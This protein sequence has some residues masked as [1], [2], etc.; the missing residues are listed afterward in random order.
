MVFKDTSSRSP[1]LHKDRFGQNWA[2]GLP[3]APRPDTRRRWPF[4]TL[5]AGTGCGAHG[6]LG[7]DP[8]PSQVTAGS[9]HIFISPGQHG[10]CRCVPAAGR[11]QGCGVRRRGTRPLR[12]LR[13]GGP[14]SPRPA[15]RT[16]SQSWVQTAQ[17][18]AAGHHRAVRCSE[19]CSVRRG[20]LVTALWPVLSCRCPTAPE[21][22]VLAVRTDRQSVWEVGPSTPEVLGD[23]R[24]ATWGGIRAEGPWSCPQRRP[25]AAGDTGAA[26]S[27]SPQGQR[28]L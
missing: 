25:G 15:G 4:P 18:E 21:Q 3:A 5:C 26:A 12:P 17:P 9:C 16:A 19:G 10:F 1:V 23:F 13:G 22:A 11:T 20:A 24:A 27:V 6:W 8:L 14:G 7:K 2:R 28:L